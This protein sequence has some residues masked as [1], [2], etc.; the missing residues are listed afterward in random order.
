[1]PKPAPIASKAF[2]VK[3]GK[4]WSVYEISEITKN[5][6]TAR[7]SRGAAPRRPDWRFFYARLLQSSAAMTGGL[8]PKVEVPVDK[9]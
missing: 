5:G 7:G 9:L 1:M 8:G 6:K 4:S 2:D 3:A